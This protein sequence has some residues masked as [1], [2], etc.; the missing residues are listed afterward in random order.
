MTKL[1]SMKLKCEGHGG[2]LQLQ[3][4]N[5]VEKGPEMR[6]HYLGEFSITCKPVKT[7]GLASGLLAPPAAPAPGAW[8]AK[9][10]TDFS[11]CWWGLLGNHL[12]GKGHILHQLAA[13]NFLKREICYP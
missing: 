4:L 3:D 2:C 12:K 6:G 9:K 1:G 5:Q 10:D 7:P 11:K 13:W 8:S